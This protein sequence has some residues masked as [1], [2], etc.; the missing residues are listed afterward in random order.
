MTAESLP[1]SPAPAVGA[2]T[3]GPLERYEKFLR[4]VRKACSTPGGRA[5]LRQGLADDLSSPWQLYMHLL[6]AGG[7]P[8]YAATREAERPYLLVACLYAVHDAP[9]PR[10]AKTTPS[11]APKPADVRK[12]LGWSYARAATTGAM[13]QQNAADALSYLAQLDTEGLYRDLPGAISLLR[14][15]RIPVQWPVLLRDLTRWPNWADDV[16]IDWVRA[17]HTP[18]RSTEENTK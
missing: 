6:P 10:T 1:A 16:R 4:I 12:N 5:A 14:S 3:P 17:F 8:A 11:P 13:R 18:A 15:H 9:N 7:I 2:A